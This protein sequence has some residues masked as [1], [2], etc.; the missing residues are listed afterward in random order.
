MR[1]AIVIGHSKASKGAGN[2]RG[3]QEWTWNRT[4][5]GQLLAE[6]GEDVAR[7][8]TR[9]PGPY[10]SAVPALAK[11]INAW[12]ADLVV[13][14]HFNASTNAA[15]HG[16]CALHW[17]GS[18]GGRTWARGL[19]EAA[20]RAIGNRDRGPVEQ[21]ESWSGLQ[22]WIL[23]ETRAPAVILESYFGTNARDTDLADA[24]LASGRLARALADRIREG[25]S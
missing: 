4:L 1:V 11:Q 24:A 16:C 22:L 20:S 8:F 12:G 19:S 10:N 2:T 13:S 6:L 7:V 3:V 25:L 18:Y 15:A 21:R 14:L 5:A 23:S 9:R 17:P